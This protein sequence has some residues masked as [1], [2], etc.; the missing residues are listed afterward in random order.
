MICGSEVVQAYMLF[1]L[2]VSITIIICWVSSYDFA[3]I[4]MTLSFRQQLLCTLRDSINS[5]L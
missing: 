1:N 5:G 4:V 2:L 3:L